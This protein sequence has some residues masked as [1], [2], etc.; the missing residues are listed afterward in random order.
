MNMKNANGNSTDGGGRDAGIEQHAEQ[1]SK[2]H[3]DRRHQH[4]TT[5]GESGA[6]RKISAAPYP[7]CYHH[8]CDHNHRK[9]IRSRLW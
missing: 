2:C 8:S 1:Q 9:R 6:A 4:K 7:S 5:A 3:I